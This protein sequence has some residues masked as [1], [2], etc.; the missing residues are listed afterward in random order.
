MAPRDKSRSLSLSLEG[1]WRDRN[2][3]LF[4][5]TWNEGFYSETLGV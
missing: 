1:L 4:V 5:V 3:L 2:K